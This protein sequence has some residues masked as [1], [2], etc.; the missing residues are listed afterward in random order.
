MAGL[1]RSMLRLAGVGGGIYMLQRGLRAVVT[2]AS[3]A[4]ETMAKF[5]T[6]FRDQ[7]ASSAVWAEEFGD[8]VGR[9]THNVAE[10]MAG[11]QDTF[12]PLGIARDKSAD[13]SKSLVKLAV[14][15]ASFNN[16]ADADVIRDFTSALVGNHETVRKYGVIISESAIKQAALNKGLNKSYKELTDL[17]KVQLRYALIMQGTT[18][19]QGDA[20]RTS[21]SYANQTKRLSA[22]VKELSASLG[23]LVLPHLADVVSW[24]NKAI[25]EGGKFQTTIGRIMS[26]TGASQS[27]IA[28]WHGLFDTGTGGTFEPA[29]PQ[30]AEHARE[31]AERREEAA[32]RQIDA[33]RNAATEE[34]SIAADTSAQVLAIQSSRVD[35]MKVYNA[36]LREDM[37]NLALYTSEKFAEAS[38]SI[39]DSMSSAFQAIIKDAGDWRSAMQNFFTS[40][41][42]AFAK[43]AADMA[44]RAAMSS[45]M[46]SFGGIGGLFG[47][48]FGGGGGAIGPAVVL[49]GGGTVG[50]D[51][52][53]RPVSAG[54]FAN[55]PRLHLGSDEVPAIL[56]KGEKVIPK[57]QAAGSV[58]NNYYIDAI[59]VESFRDRLGG[60][61]E[62]IADLHFD[63]NRRN[64]KN[65]RAGG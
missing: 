2:E 4:E 25:E 37:Q 28:R 17:E 26:A 46:G 30:A 53:V 60:Q 3:K 55:A 57:G 41:G 59:D 32:A 58:V 61:Q 49:H 54:T 52:V 39:E 13:L 31:V 50:R 34:V 14:D 15:V 8:S 19:A 1:S 62:F 22:N 51:G 24:M 20:I 42:N 45:I 65:R 23:T 5:N 7:A 10:W 43:M 35:A 33:A 64:H 11:L 44:A 38:R 63:S 21:D 47:G 16:K 56:Q 36:E 12:V 18:D 9:A 27:D 6:V 29:T 40:V 48:L